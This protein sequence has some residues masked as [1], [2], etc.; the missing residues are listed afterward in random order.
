MCWVI[1]HRVSL[2]S[3]ILSEHPP[4][5][6]HI[7]AQHIHTYCTYIILSVL[8]IE[9]AIHRKLSYISSSCPSVY[10]L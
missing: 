2:M 4:K 7:A 8:E 10:I 9:I 3:F 5:T 1:S 6:F